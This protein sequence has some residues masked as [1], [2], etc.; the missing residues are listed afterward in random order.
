MAILNSTRINGDLEVDG[1]ILNGSKTN[2]AFYKFP[3]EVD[4]NGNDIGLCRDPDASLEHSLTITTHGNPVFISCNGDINP[5]TGNCWVRVFL[6][7]DDTQI[8]VHVA[9][10][11]LSGVNR[12]FC[13]NFL[14]KVP[15]GTHTYKV[16]ITVYN[17]RINFADISELPDSKKEG[18]NFLVFEI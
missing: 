6:Y 7:R 13:T 1:A 12:P 3:T 18:P 2:Y 9:Q 17:A 15:A 11:R 5:E 8:S 4:G 14:D 16:K 10:S